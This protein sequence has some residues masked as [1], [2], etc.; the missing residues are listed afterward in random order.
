LWLPKVLRSTL[1]GILTS[2]GLTTII[3]GVFGIATNTDIITGRSYK[4]MEEMISYIVT[5]AGIISGILALW[6]KQFSQK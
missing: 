1:L 4:G 6:V 3:Y 5:L 2:I